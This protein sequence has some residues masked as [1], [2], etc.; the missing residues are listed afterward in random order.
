VLGERLSGLG[1]PVLSGVPAGHID[2]NAE[3]P[4]GARVRVD[5]ARAELTFLEPAARCS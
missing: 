1:V 3:L 2:D 5:A 4:L